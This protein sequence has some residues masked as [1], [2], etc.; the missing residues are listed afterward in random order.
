MAL[1]K[2]K[3]EEILAGLVAKLEESPDILLSSPQ[4]LSTPQMDALRRRLAKVPASHR[5]VK[6]T[7]LKLAL[8]K[9]G[10]SV[11]EPLLQGATAVSFCPGDIATAA[12]VLLGYSVEVPNFILKGGVLGGKAFGTDQLRTLTQLPSREVL[13]GQVLGGMQ[14][15]LVRLASVLQGPMQG[16]ARVLKARTEQLEKTAS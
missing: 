3:K 13:L 10:A 11:P 1:T 4:G 7:L 5:V 15:P 12:R 2:A 8:E 6:N 16:L 14:A 9:S